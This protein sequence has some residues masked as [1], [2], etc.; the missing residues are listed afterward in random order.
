MPSDEIC[1]LRGP[2]TLPEIKHMLS[3]F[4]REEIFKFDL[5]SVSFRNFFMKKEA[6]TY[7][8]NYANSVS[9]LK[10]PQASFR[11]ACLAC[12]FLSLKSQSIF[13]FF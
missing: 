7:K 12:L 9:I 13:S 3:S 11:L 6:M 2:G 10:V 8:V 4:S 1:R 5:F